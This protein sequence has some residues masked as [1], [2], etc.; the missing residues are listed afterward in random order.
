MLSRYRIS[1]S[2]ALSSRCYRYQYMLYTL[3]HILSKRSRMFKPGSRTCARLE[4]AEKENH[5]QNMAD[6]TPI[7]ALS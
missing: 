4:K 1:Y 2:L 3:Y 6:Q 5:Y 7:N